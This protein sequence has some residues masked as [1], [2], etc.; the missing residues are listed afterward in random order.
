MMTDDDDDTFTKFDD[1]FLGNTQTEKRDSL[2]VRDYTIINMLIL[3]TC[4][5]YTQPIHTH[6]H[7]HTQSCAYIR[8]QFVSK[9]Q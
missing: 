3:F 1:Y 4:I 6:T 9:M 2:F 5:L 7:T 8:W